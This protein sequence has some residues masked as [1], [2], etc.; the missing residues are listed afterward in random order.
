MSVEHSPT[1]ITFRFFDR[2]ERQSGNGLFL[3][4]RTFHHD[5]KMNPGWGGWGVHAHP[6]HFNLFSITYKIA[7]FAPAEG[8]DTLLVFY[9]YPICTSRSRDFSNRRDLSNS[10]DLSNTVAGI[11]SIAGTPTEASMPAQQ[12]SCSAGE[13]ST[14]AETSAESEH[15]K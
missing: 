8:A 4:Y 6:G 13:T 1:Q 9:P 14:T 12:D 3:A 10:R 5:G 2:N 7:V 15:G 11:S